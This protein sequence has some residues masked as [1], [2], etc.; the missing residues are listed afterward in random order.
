MV[1]LALITFPLRRLLIASF[2]E[3]VSVCSSVPGQIS[4]VIQE[5]RTLEY[6]STVKVLAWEITYRVGN[7]L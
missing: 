7:N 3:T 2:T 1:E 4:D 5:I 6:F